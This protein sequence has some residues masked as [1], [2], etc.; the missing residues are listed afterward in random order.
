MGA[1]SAIEGPKLPRFY[2]DLNRARKSAPIGRDAVHAAGEPGAGARGGAHDDAR[3]GLA[4]VHARP[5]PPGAR[6]VAGS[7]AL[8]FSLF[9]KSPAHSLT[10]LIPPDG[11]RCERGRQAPAR[12]A[13]HL[14][15]RRTGSPEGEDLPRRP[16]GR[17]R[18]G[19]HPRHSRRAR[20]VRGDAGRPA[21]VGAGAVAAAGARGVA[22]GVIAAG[23]RARAGASR[24]MIPSAR[25]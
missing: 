14:R 7:K 15:R 9:S 12:D 19:R 13:R 17:L 25:P 10:S 11:R 22:G 4:E 6:D 2:W 8:G 23:V 24:S 16:H 5:P 21:T 20:G 1:A 18:P 3:G